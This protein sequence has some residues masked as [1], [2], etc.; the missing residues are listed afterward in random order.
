MSEQ[1][2]SSGINTPSTESDSPKN[3]QQSIIFAPAFK[4]MVSYLK[5]KGISANALN[6]SATP[7]GR[8]TRADTESIVYTEYS[9]S[10]RIIELIN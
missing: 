6:R 9:I 10:M 5:S 4:K 1:D 2:L 8:T 3:Q 7:A